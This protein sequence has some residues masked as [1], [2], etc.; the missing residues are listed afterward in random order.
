[1]LDGFR[2]YAA[3]V[4]A[5]AGC[6]EALSEGARFCPSCGTPLG[7]QSPPREER[8]VVSILFVDLVGFT[9][10]A[11]RADPELVRDLLRAYHAR[12]R[13]ELERFGGTVEKFIGDAVMAVF[14]APLAHDD[15][16]ERAVRAGLEALTGV[17]ELPAPSG[18]TLSAR[19]AVA[20]GEAV[21]AMADTRRG[22][23][24]A[25]GDV[26][27]TASRLQ[28][29]APIGRLVV[30]DETRRATR[31]TVHYSRLDP[32][33]AKG[34]ANPVAAWAADGF[35]DASGVPPLGSG[36]LVGREDELEQLHGTWRRVSRRRR[37]Q[38]V[39]VVGAAGTGKSRLVQEF[40]TGVDARVVTGRC[41]PYEHSAA[42]GAF[43][44][45]LRHLAGI[46]EADEA[47]TALAKL[48]AL[49]TRL[50][51]AAEVPEVRRCAATLFAVAPAEPAAGETAVLLYAYRRLVEAAALEQPMVLV[52]E[53]VHWA[54]PA[55]YEL[56]RYLAQF[57][58]EVPV[59][60]LTLARPELL[61]THPDWGAG[62]L[63]YTA[64]PLEPLSDDAAAAV[65]QAS[66]GR[67]LAPDVVSRLVIA[68]AGN[69]LFLEELAI[70]L[71]EGIGTSE[72]IPTSV[73]AAIAA[74]V[75]ALPPAARSVLLAASVVGRTFWAGAIR[76][77]TGDEHDG[78]DAH[79]TGETLAL[80]EARDLVRR[81]PAS[82][83]PGDVAYRF[84]HAL[85]R[86]VCYA[87][88]PRGDRARAHAATARYLEERRA[89][90][91]ELAW[92]LAHHHEIAGDTEAAIRYLLVAADR[93]QAVLAEQ[94]TVALLDRAEQLATDDTTRTRIRHARG[95]ALT[96]FENYDD[97][98]A[99]LEAVLSELEGDALLDALLDFARC[100]H[101]TERTADTIAISERA[102]HLARELGREDAAAAALARLSQGYAMRG[103][104]GDLAHA[105]EL[106]EQALAD[107]PHDVRND[108]RAEH[109]HL[110]G[111]QHYWA[112]NLDRA[113]T[114]ARAARQTAV[115][116]PGSAEAQLRGAGMEALLLAGL[117]RYQDAL[118]TFDNALALAEN[119]GRPRRVMTN[120]STLPFRELFDLEQARAR[121]EWVL[122]GI[123]RSSFHM[124]WMN[125]AADL[126]HVEVLA[127]DWGAARVRWESLYPEVIETPAWERWLLGTKLAT[128]RADIALHE[129]DLASAV[130][131]AELA[132][133]SSRS[134]GRVKYELHAHDVLGRALAALGSP[135]QAR[136]H[137]A[138]A[139]TMADHGRNPHARL[140]THAHA[141]RVLYDLGDDDAAATHHRV[142]VQVV[143]DVTAGLPAQRAAA[144]RAA[145][146][147]PV[148]G[149]YR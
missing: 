32:V 148:E 10:T 82:E 121:S 149:D 33:L 59:M 80:L 72:D 24:L 17:A 68:G 47:G 143:D 134:S 73:R 69:P 113:L 84:K 3:A 22:E 93:T 28:A 110:L 126:V 137:L 129:R 124:P 2:P 34:K 108:D 50:L 77:A 74:R 115:D 8:K 67:S 130:T 41:V 114:L 142:A 70:S 75:D 60:V 76:S 13:G 39:A 139:T 9:S 146:P 44:Q 45:Q 104:S 26:V 100:C 106:G 138:K 64:L 16:A 132:L 98:H 23:A 90:S 141:A 40:T 144:Y 103:E 25:M 79:D 27:N 46:D 35:I 125:A 112:G 19:A 18:G 55:E 97:G 120:Y 81:Q 89:G 43:A 83:L 63:A 118:T 117:G 133:T 57:V 31:R 65:I 49:L 54:G 88:L 78:V 123:P 91:S 102:L 29:A 38:L 66:A 1:M 30:D 135:D 42:Y 122:D 37:P 53:D 52:F 111:D 71:A 145:A 4:G 94:E 140:L 116:D 105:L 99:T 147:L 95:H 15:D 119:M 92:L 48:D 136:R 56:I 96:R 128:F 86:D 36:P 101:W 61:E 6:G 11:D 131:W 21:V 127:R 58:R 12:V 7:E 85:I 62:L 51:P 109:E 107:W 87:T 5:C 14:G 20:T